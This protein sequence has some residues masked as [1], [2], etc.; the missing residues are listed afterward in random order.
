MDVLCS[1]YDFWMSIDDVSRDFM[2]LRW[3]FLDAFYHFCLVVLSFSSVKRPLFVG[4]KLVA[5]SPM[6]L[7]FP[8]K[9]NLC[10]R[11]VCSTWRGCFCTDLGFP[12]VAGLEGWFVCCFSGFVDLILPFSFGAIGL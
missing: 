10:S 3:H 2:L 7:V 9:Q 5:F 11:H 8:M 4:V 6:W 12:V 1:G